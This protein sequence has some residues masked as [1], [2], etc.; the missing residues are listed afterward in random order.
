[1]DLRWASLP[2]SNLPDGATVIKRRLRVGH[3]AEVFVKH[4]GCVTRHVLLVEGDVL[5]IH[6]PSGVNV[7][8]L[9]A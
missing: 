3:F 8:K 6:T 2:I 9:A 5:K 4:N 1:M 7:R